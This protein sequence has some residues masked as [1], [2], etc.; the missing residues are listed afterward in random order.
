[1]KASAAAI[2][3]G[4]LCLRCFQS[5]QH[6]CT[7]Y[8]TSQARRLRYDLAVGRDAATVLSDGL[9]LPEEERARVA[10]ELFAS[11]ESRDPE[12]SAELSLAWAR[13]VEE[14]IDR[15]AR[16][17]SQ[18]VDLDVARQRVETALADT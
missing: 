16:G 3:L 14:R 1:M 13:T 9:A 11:L 5:T 6:V 18:G 8:S 12:Y 7:P 15:F 2:S 17:E 10:A 4:L